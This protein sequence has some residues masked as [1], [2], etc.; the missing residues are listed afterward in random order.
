MWLLILVII[1]GMI[2]YILN[3]NKKANDYRSPSKKEQYEISSYKR[4]SNVSF[5][6][7]NNDKGYI[8][9]YLI[10]EMLN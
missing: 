4:A 3:E 2:L 1:I 8:G 5:Y 9:E 10:F 6:D 7:A